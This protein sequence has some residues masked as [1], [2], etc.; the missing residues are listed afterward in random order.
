MEFDYV[1]MVQNLQDFDLAQRGERE[2]GVV[3]TLA[4]ENFLQRKIF[5]WVILCE[6]F[7]NIANERNLGF[8]IR[9]RIT[10]RPRGQLFRLSRNLSPC[11]RSRNTLH[12]T[13]HFCI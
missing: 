9:G 5:G 7:V 8:E 13:H 11:D 6:N 2:A 12:N 10:R 4:R 1:W 3:L